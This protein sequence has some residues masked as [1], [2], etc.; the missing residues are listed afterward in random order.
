M[1]SRKLPIGIQSF[2]EMRTGGYAYVDKTPFIHRLIR[3]G[4]YYFLSRPRRFG[5]SL[6]IDTCDAAFSQKRDLFTG[7]FLDSPESDWDWT[8]KN[9]VLR[10]DWSLSSP[11][12]PGDLNIHIQHSSHPGPGTGRLNSLKRQ[13]EDGYQPS[14]GRFIPEP[15]SRL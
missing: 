9:P 10:I 12:T 5:K 8:R 3:S 7:L 14:S 6:L 4:K 15:E 11:R 2:Q 1:T 13:S